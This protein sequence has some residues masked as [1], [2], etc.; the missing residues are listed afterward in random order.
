MMNLESLRVLKA[1]TTKLADEL[2]AAVTATNTKAAAIK[3]DASRSPAWKDEQINALRQQVLA[4]SGAKF[5]ELKAGADRAGQQKR[6]WSSKLMALR[7]ARFD[8]DPAKDAAI[9]A[10]R[11]RDIADMPAALLQL[12]GEAAIANNNWPELYLAVVNAQTR[13]GEEGFAGFDMEPVTPPQQAEALEAIAA[14]VAMGHEAEHLIA[15]ASGR[16]LSPVSRLA[17]ARQAVA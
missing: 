3:E 16:T 6:Y 1:S 11:A 8:A 7:L 2:R 10:D 9:R 17:A 15:L 14:C 13:M 5:S 4:A 12:V